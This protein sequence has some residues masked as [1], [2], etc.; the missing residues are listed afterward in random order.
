MKTGVAVEKL[1]SA[2]ITKT[3]LRYDAPQST[4]GVRLDIFYPPNSDRLE[5]KRSFSTATGH[6]THAGVNERNDI[7]STDQA[8][9]RRY[10]WGRMVGELP[11]RSHSPQ[12]K[13]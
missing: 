1:P 2:K 6:F 5:R 10:S 9:S 4:F 11:K 3:K 12:N 7:S 13:T 8:G